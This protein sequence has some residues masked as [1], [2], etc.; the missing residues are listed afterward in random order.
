MKVGHCDQELVEIPRVNIIR[1]LSEGF[2]MNVPGRIVHIPTKL[3]FDDQ[4]N[5]IPSFPLTF[6][7][8]KGFNVLNPP[9]NI[10]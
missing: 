4:H 7:Y 10:S 3:V 5:N 6:D 9:R 8:M 2:S 1:M